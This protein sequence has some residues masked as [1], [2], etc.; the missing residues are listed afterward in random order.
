MPVLNS[1]ALLSYNFGILNG[2]ASTTGPKIEFNKARSFTGGPVVSG[3]TLGE[4]YFGGADSASA[5]SRKLGID[6]VS[7]GTIGP[8]RIPFGLR[9]YTAQDAALA[10]Q[11]VRMVITS[12]GQVSVQ[13]SDSDTG[14]IGTPTV[15]F[16]VRGSTAVANNA[17]STAGAYASL[18]KDRAGA[19]IVS[20]DALGELGFSGFDGTS[21][22]EAGGISCVSTGTVAAGKVPGI[23]GFLTMSDSAGT[24]L[25]RML[26]G[27][28]GNVVISPPTSGTAL[29]ANGQV[30]VL[31]DAGVGTA[32]AVD[33][34]NTTDLTANAAG[35][36][37]V[38]SK[39]ANNLDSSGFLKIY[40]NGTTYYIPLFSAVAP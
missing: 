11:V 19:T 2:D 25:P 16:V 22:I 21:F 36:F 1:L 10:P 20:G 7:V 15:T 14:T 32:S 28:E 34:T 35:T 12:G 30:A 18:V 5:F 29:E 24:L 9:F 31:G 33:F 6:A 27:P 26:I 40:V 3:D 17:N 23:L 13:Q 39:S 4:I 8:D 37:T 38:K